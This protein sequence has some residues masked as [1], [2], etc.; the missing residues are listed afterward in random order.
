MVGSTSTGDFLRLLSVPPQDEIRFSSSFQESRIGEEAEVIGFDQRHI[1]TGR[2]I[3]SFSCF[4]IMLSLLIGCGKSG[5][6]VAGGGEAEV[7]IYCSVDQEYAEQIVYAFHEAHPEIKVSTRFDT[8]TTKTTGLV[9]RLRA[10]RAN[11]RADLFWSSEIF[12]T[13]RLAQDGLLKR[14]ETE[15]VRDWPAEYRDS[16]WRWYAFAGRAR[17]IAYD[18]ARTN[19]PP[20]NWWDLTDAKYRGRVAMADPVFGTTRGHVA[21]W[22]WWWGR[23]EAEGFLRRLKANGLRVVTSNS[24]TVRELLQETVDFAITDTDDVWAARRNGHKLAVVYPNHGAWRGDE[25]KG[26]GNGEGTL[27]IPN[28][29]AFVAGRAETEAVRVFAEF[30]LSERTERILYESD[31]HHVPLVFPDAIEVDR[32]YRVPGHIP[33]DYEK[34]SAGMKDAIDSAVRNLAGG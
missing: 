8:E 33:V 23:V 19:D 28:T 31:S 21:T 7:I 9:Q 11:P 1:G 32:R 22:Y 2:M 4:A 34:V 12:Q 5:G 3:R 27:I 26:E 13:I 16:Q 29:L 10:E 30:I 25:R 24:Q 6:G 17:V 14:F 15:A 18:P 20:V